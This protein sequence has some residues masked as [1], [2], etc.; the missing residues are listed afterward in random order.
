M[1]IRL[2]PMSMWHFFVLVVSF[3]NHYY[4]HGPKYLK[5][6]TF[7]LPNTIAVR[8]KTLLCCPLSVYL[9]HSSK[10]RATLHAW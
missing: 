2:S 7:S 6:T 10:V 9:G 3:V 1:E 4:R 5:R 8:D